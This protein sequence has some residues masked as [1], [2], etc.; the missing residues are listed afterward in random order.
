MNQRR[1]PINIVHLRLSIIF[2]DDRRIIP[3]LKRNHPLPLLLVHRPTRDFF[4]VRIERIRE[5]D[6]RARHHFGRF[7]QVGR[8]GVAR[9]RELGGGQIGGGARG[10]GGVGERVG[11]RWLGVDV[12]NVGGMVDPERD[13][14]RCD[15]RRLCKEVTPDRCRIFGDC[16]REL[17]TPRSLVE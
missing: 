9:V 13:E 17:G 8:R 14:R 10:V 16:S 1:V 4:P 6:P 7:V 3:S 15:G 12:G 5:M 11:G 2:G